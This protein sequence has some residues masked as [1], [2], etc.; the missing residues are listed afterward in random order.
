MLKFFTNPASKYAYLRSLERENFMIWP[1][2]GRGELVEG[3]KIK[4]ILKFVP[5]LLLISVTQDSH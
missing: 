4:K 5:S 2:P 3:I 1:T